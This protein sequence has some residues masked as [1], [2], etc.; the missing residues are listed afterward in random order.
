MFSIRDI[1]DKYRG[2]Y[3]GISWTIINPLIM[4]AIYTV[5][6]SQI[7]KVRWGDNIYASNP[8]IFAINLFA[9]LIVFNI[10]AESTARGPSLIAGNPNYVKKIKFPIEVLG[11]TATLTATS[12]AIVSAILLTIFQLLTT[13]K[14]C[15]TIALLPLIWTPLILGVLGLTWLL[16]TI[17]VFVKDINQ[18]NNSFISMTMFMSPVFYPKDAFPEKLKILTV[19]NPL[20]YIIE[21]TRMVLIEG[22]MPNIGVVVVSI[23]IS[24]VW[25]EIAYRIMKSKQQYMGDQL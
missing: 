6:F 22:K 10:F 20:G 14:M 24:L 11:I 1:Q 12:N 7:F 16:S 13:N 8:T 18:V 15:A 21:K 23:I 4:L 17:G 9:G 5:V 3:I 25:C 19:L 2:S